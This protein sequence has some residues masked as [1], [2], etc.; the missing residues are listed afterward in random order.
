MNDGTVTL[1]AKEEE[2]QSVEVDVWVQGTFISEEAALELPDVLLEE[3]GASFSRK[4]DNIWGSN[5]LKAWEM[6]CDRVSAEMETEEGDE[7]K[8]DEKVEVDVVEG[9]DSPIVHRAGPCTGPTKPRSCSLHCEACLK[10][11]QTEKQRKTSWSRREWRRT[12]RKKW[13]RQRKAKKMADR[14]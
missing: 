11:K 3:F 10:R 5:C 4:A 2:R 7:V 8:E 12:D 13:K 14:T 6:A 9:A 1:R